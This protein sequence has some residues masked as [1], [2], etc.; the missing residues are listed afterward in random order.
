MSPEMR[1]RESLNSV[2]LIGMAGVG[3]S[4]VGRMLAERMQSRFIDSD[5]YIRRA[6]GRSLQAIINEDGI[7]MFR[8]KETQAICSINTPDSV[9]ATGGSAIYEPKAM[10]HL[11]S[12]CFIIWLRA[13]T[14]VIQ[15]RIGSIIH[16]GLAS[17]AG[18]SIDEIMNEREPLYERYA[19]R[20]IDCSSSCASTTA[21]KV[22]AAL[23]QLRAKP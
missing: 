3:K 2:A 16:R 9:I 13:D 22:Q 8:K 5:D 10:A 6:D 4:T 18:L 1:Q 12:F 7:D 15:A 19:D 14:A 21:S 11:S 20:V 17:D 23:K